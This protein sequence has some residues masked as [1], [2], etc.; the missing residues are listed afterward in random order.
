M[1]RVAVCLKR[2]GCFFRSSKN[3]ADKV[4][5]AKVRKLRRKAWSDWIRCFTLFRSSKKS[6]ALLL[7]LSCRFCVDVGGW[8]AFPVALLISR[9]HNYSKLKLKRKLLKH[10]KTRLKLNVF[11]PSPEIC[12]PL[13]IISSLNALILTLLI[14]MAESRNMRFFARVEHKMS[15]V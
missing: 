2:L 14:L 11:C 1:N 6:F 13:S 4:D 5:K 12:R 15:R 3:Y 9:E 7:S 10:I 8:A